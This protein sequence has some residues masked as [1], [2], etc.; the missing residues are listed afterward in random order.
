MN[1]ANTYLIV[2]S[3]GQVLLGSCTVRKPINQLRQAFDAVEHGEAD[4]FAEVVAP[5]ATFTFMNADARPLTAAV[6]RARLSR[7]C[8][9]TEFGEVRAEILFARGSCDQKTP[10][11]DNYPIFFQAYLRNGKIVRVDQMVYPL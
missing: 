7:G 2:G 9:L 1:K 3:L 8:E 5:R 6:L 4:A 11:G 10:Y